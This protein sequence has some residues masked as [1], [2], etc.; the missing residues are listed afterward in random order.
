[1]ENLNKQF[2]E[3]KKSIEEQE[4]DLGSKKKEF[5]ELKNEEVSLESKLSLSKSEAEQASKTATDTQLEISQIKA[6]VVELEEYE[7][8]VNEM[9]SDYDY[10]INN[11]DIVKI[12][13][14]LPRSI[15]PPPFVAMDAQPIDDLN[16]SK[17]FSSDPFADE[18]PF[19]G[20]ILFFENIY[21]YN[22][23]WFINF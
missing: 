17:E 10:A 6:N 21:F 12:A 2:I 4:V 18:D 19:K 22:C 11:H 7:R 8:R 23:F 16:V 15:T 13:S 1:M 3:Q 20:L 5:E 9:L 14:L